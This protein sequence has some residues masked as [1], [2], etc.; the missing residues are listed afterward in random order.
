MSIILK[1]VDILNS[2]LFHWSIEAYRY[3]L[4]LFTLYFGIYIFFTFIPVAT[5]GAICN[6]EDVDGTAKLLEEKK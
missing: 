2:F 4:F 3:L 1:P 6:S 5:F